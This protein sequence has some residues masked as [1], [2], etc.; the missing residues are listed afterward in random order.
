MFQLRAIPSLP[1]K[2]R[3]SNHLSFSISSY[4]AS[5]R[6]FVSGLEWIARLILMLPCVGDFHVSSV[7]FEPFFFPVP[8]VRLLLLLYYIHSLTAF[9]TTLCGG[10][11]VLFKLKSFPSFHTCQRMLTVRAIWPW[12]SGWLYEFA[13]HGNSSSIG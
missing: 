3:T 12:P 8:L 1:R 2:C 5:F 13:L 7:L 6:L 10:V 4:N 11:L 9:C